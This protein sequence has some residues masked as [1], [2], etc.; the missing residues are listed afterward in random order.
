M[1]EKEFQEFFSRNCR[2]QCNYADKEKGEIVKTLSC[3]LYFDI[4]KIITLSHG[5]VKIA[6][7]TVTDGE[8]NDVSIEDADVILAVSLDSIENIHVLHEG[9][10]DWQFHLKDGA[11]FQFRN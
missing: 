2:D 7:A 5:V 9:S 3:G 8:Y 1:T 6:S 10:D 4:V 11:I